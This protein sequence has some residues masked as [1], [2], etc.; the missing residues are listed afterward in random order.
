MPVDSRRQ[1]LE[2]MTGLAGTL[3]L[4]TQ[5][6][7]G[8]NDRIRIGVIGCGARGGELML[9]ARRCPGAEIAAC[10]DI[11]TRRLEEVRRILPTAG[12]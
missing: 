3:A 10:A 5:T 6:V 11:Y 12:E 9:Q 7:L 4:P 8:A 2:K 1:F